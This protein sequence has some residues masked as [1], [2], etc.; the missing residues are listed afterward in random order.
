MPQSSKAS[1]VFPFLY[2]GAESDLTE[3]AIEKSKITHVLNATKTLAKPNNIKEANFKRIPV[4]D[5]NGETI[6]T[7]LDECVEFIDQRRLHNQRVL[8]HCVAGI[9]RSATISIAYTMKHLNMTVDKAY[10]YVKQKRPEISPNLGFMGQLLEYQ[11]G[12]KGSET[13]KEETT[14]TRQLPS[15]LRP[16]VGELKA[17]N[18]RKDRSGLSLVLG[19]K[20][21]KKEV[22]EPIIPSKRARPIRPTCLLLTT[23][24][25]PS[26]S[27]SDPITPVT[28]GPKEKRTIHSDSDFFL[29]KAKQRIRHSSAGNDSD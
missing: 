14:V 10:D 17:E 18:T 7:Y 2:L 22:P 27:K 4:L 21:R 20:R 9:S 28:Q 11:N 5:S 3:T 19:Q 24:A 12:L 25:P 23:T 29:F 8:V 16:V 15:I 13:K 1:E 26:R 6:L